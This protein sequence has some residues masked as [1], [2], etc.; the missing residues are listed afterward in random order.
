MKATLESVMVESLATFGLPEVHVKYTAAEWQLVRKFIRMAR[1]HMDTLETELPQED[2][3]VYKQMVPVFVDIDEK[4]GNSLDEIKTKY[5][6]A[7]MAAVRDWHRWDFSAELAQNVAT[8][9]EV[10]Q[11]IKEEEEAE[12]AAVVA[13]AQGT[14][15]AGGGPSTP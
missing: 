14:P 13:I 4:V 10:A 12:A 11:M 15:P 8:E 7:N 5:E 2:R 9:E 6:D 1:E 3:L